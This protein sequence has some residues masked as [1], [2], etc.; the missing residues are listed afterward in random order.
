[1]IDR[2]H[3]KILYEEDEDLYEY[4]EF[5]D[6]SA[7]Y[8]QAGVEWED[9]EEVDCEE[10]EIEVDIEKMDDDDDE[11]SGIK[12]ISVSATGELV[13]PSGRRLGLRELRRYYKQR[14]RP[15]ENRESVLAH[16]KERLLLMYQSAGI[17][18]K[19]ALSLSA[20]KNI[21]NRRRGNITEHRSIQESVSVR[22]RFA[23]H[24]ERLDYRSHKLQKYPNRRVMI[25]V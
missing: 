15:T 18:M 6:F 8:D 3:C 22:H 21:L 16:T 2:S 14:H 10:G 25:T 23:K 24:R 20:V 5:Y 13:L 7:S 9:V 1:M 17:E 19:S 11:L 4:E 12:T